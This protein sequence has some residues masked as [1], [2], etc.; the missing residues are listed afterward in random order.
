[1]Q[2]RVAAAGWASFLA[3][4]IACGAVEAVVGDAEPETAPARSV[5]APAPARGPITA[6]GR[7]EPKDGL[8]QVAGP[9]Q[10]SVVVSE[11]LVAKGD[12][13]RHGQ[14]VAHLDTTEIHHAQVERLEAELA[15]AQADLARNVRLHLGKVVSEAKL[16]SWQLKVRVLAADLRRARAELAR[17]QVRAPIDGQ[18]VDIHAYPGERV[19]LD[20]IV[21]LA[22]TD[23][24]YAIAEVYETEI[25]RVKPGQRASV[26]SAALPEPL[27]GRVEW[28]K[29]KVGK[30]DVL[31]TDPAAK[32]DARVVEVEIR[33]DDGDA[34]A[35]LTNLQ[36]EVTIAP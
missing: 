24:I 14:I 20:G 5:A 4:G 6:L 18:V 17:S 32:T 23:E 15:Q 7:I 33:L 9:S 12:R 2:V 3:L 35:A 10:P 11:L 16:D 13:V 27:L 8:I 1:M 36:V 31:G 22:R 25:G 21:E 26:A 28:I 34:A 30:L 19:G 29:P